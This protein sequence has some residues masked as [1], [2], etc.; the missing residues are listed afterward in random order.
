MEKQVKMINTGSLPLE[1]VG[2]SSEVEVG[3]VGPGGV[4]S[5]T[6][7]AL[8]ESCR[9]EN[10]GTGQRERKWAKHFSLNLHLLLMHLS[11][12]PHRI[13]SK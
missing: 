4:T 10:E 6:G 1:T 11:H 8:A 3:S 2:N 9:H 13:D 12:P 5:S 7:L